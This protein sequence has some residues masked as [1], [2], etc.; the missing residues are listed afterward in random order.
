MTSAVG[1]WDQYPPPTGGS[2]PP[3]LTP[4]VPLDAGYVNYW[5]AQNAV[6]NTTFQGST[7]T[8]TGITLGAIALTG[9]D[10]FNCLHK[11]GRHSGASINVSV[12]HCFPAEMVQGVSGVGGFV[13]QHTFAPNH[14]SNA[15][16]R[17]GHGIKQTFGLPAVGSDPS[18]LLN[19]VF[20]GFDSADT[21]YQVMQNDGAGTCTKT[22]LGGSWPGRVTARGAVYRFTISTVGGSGSYEWVFERLDTAAST[23]GS[24]S[25]NV[26][27]N[28]IPMLPFSYVNTG[29][30]A[31]TDI[32]L[33]QAH[34]F[35][36]SAM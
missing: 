31:A 21:N 35:A 29:P 28:S 22:D 32:E 2:A 24:V 12:G 11:F 16:C 6:D 8:L 5:T 7:S 15:S 14:G 34:G 25:S 26:P 36:R 1:Y 4:W 19:C 13:V 10:Y 27:A 18:V 33:F 23:S 30:S 17:A 20:I 3:D 9:A